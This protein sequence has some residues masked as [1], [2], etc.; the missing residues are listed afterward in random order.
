MPRP[1]PVALL[2]IAAAASL[3]LIAALPHAAPATPAHALVLVLALAAGVALGYALGRR[4][5]GPLRERVGRMAA[6]EAELRASEARVRAMLEHCTDF[7]TLI[8][9]DGTILYESPSA[10][11]LGYRAAD[12]VGTRVWDY[13]HPDDAAAVRRRFREIADNPGRIVPLTGRLRHH[14]GSWR[15]LEGS[16][17]FVP[18]LFGPGAVVA[19]TRDVT[20]R[21]RAEADLRRTR[22]FLGA[23]VEHLPI[24]V[25][26]KDVRA[27]FAI[28]LW[29][30]ENERLFGMPRDAVVGKRDAD[31]WPGSADGYA[32]ADRRV[33]A[34]REVVDVPEEPAVTAD[35]RRLLLH[36]RKVPLVGDDGDVTHLLGISEDI[37]PLRRARE[38]LERA[39]AAAEAASR[40]K[41]EFLANMSHEIRT[42][43]NGILGM[44]ELVLDTPLTAAQREYLALVKQSADTLLTLINDILDFSKVEAGRLDLHPA[45]FRV[46]DAVDAAVR[47]LAVRARQKGLAVDCRVA[48]D[49]PEAAVGD[50]GRFRQVLINL[51]GNAVKF[52]DRGGVTVDVTADDRDAGGWTAHVAVADTGPG[53]PPAHIR[54]VFD[55]FAQGDTALTRRHGG[56]GLG[57]AISTRLAGLMGGRLWLESAV[58]RG[59]TFHFTA[60]L[61]SAAAADVPDP[62]AIGRA[63]GAGVAAA[64]RPLRV[65]VAEDQPVNQRLAARLLEMRGHAAVVVGNGREAVD[66]VA[67]GGF[68]AVLMDVQMPEMDGLTA[69]GL[70]RERE[71]GT[72]RRLPVVAVTAYAMPGDAARCLAAGCDAYLTKP[73]DRDALF[74]VVE[75]LTADGA[76]SNGPHDGPPPP[77][78]PA[79]PPPAA[80]PAATPPQAAG[81]HAPARAF[82]AAEALARVD[83]D[84]AFFRELVGL[85]FGRWAESLAELR[86]AADAGDAGRAQR[87]AHALK[88]GLAALGATAAFEAARDR[89]AEAKAGRADGL[90]PLI[91]RLD[92]AV[93]EFR[94]AYEG[95]DKAV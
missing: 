95:Y 59:S 57:L 42:P 43:M 92:A 88:G 56:T 24:G 86:A 15:W 39:K 82:D 90:P 54:T 63:A 89:H 16:G 9:A 38:E 71:A 74:A 87:A 40:A 85:F 25:F 27:G 48:A 76:G 65:L 83:G 22:D 20:L 41:S 91:A 7:I 30:R 13:L 2:S 4:G 28:T 33:V 46:R 14:D 29:N 45:A 79:T 18:D 75:R 70:I 3:V 19:N 36:T 60:R 68:D 62:A 81:G 23:I 94:A 72:G 84:E 49:V 58:G 66:A 51:V 55:A 21:K 93:G 37:T 44:T 34:G 53:I 35:G 17:R 26:V 8:A 12:L 10:E 69:T 31:L 11:Q 52:T 47:P 67:A 32:D 6:T 78:P 61:G 64:A 73:I 5:V 1:K 80:A 50:A 77:A